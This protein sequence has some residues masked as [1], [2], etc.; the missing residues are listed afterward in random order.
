MLKQ[1]IIVGGFTFLARIY[2]HSHTILDYRSRF[3]LCFAASGYVLPLLSSTILLQLTKRILAQWKDILFFST[4]SDV[5]L[6]DA[7]FISL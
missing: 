3:W 6:M 1:T 4:N 7:L 5:M 2:Q